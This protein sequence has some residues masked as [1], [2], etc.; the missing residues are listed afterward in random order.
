MRARPAEGRWGMVLR[1]G[2]VD[3]VPRGVAGARGKGGQERAA[4]QQQNRKK[5]RVWWAGVVGWRGALDSTLCRVREKG[6]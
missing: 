4:Q 6:E 5:R 2:T 1:R 3:C